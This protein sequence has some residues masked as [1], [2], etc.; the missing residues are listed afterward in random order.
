MIEAKR[1][2][3]RRAEAREA[4]AR[5]GKAP[6][7][8]SREGK[9][10]EGKPRDGSENRDGLPRKPRDKSHR[11]SRRMDIIDQLDATSIYGT[12]RMFCP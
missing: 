1:R 11:P 8:S 7:G 10:R 3:R 12:G 6:E 4:A 5:D 9:A 2:E